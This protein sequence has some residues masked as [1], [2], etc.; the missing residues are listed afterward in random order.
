MSAES[1]STAPTEQGPAGEAEIVACVL[2]Y[3]EGW[4]EGDPA[5][6]R[7]ALHPGLAKRALL[8][9]EQSLDE[10][11]A[12]QMI[13]ATGRGGGT[14]RDP[15]RIE[16][17]VEDVYGSIAAATVRSAVYREY[18]QLARTQDGW[19]IVNALWAWT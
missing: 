1:P 9:D 5:R 4:F 15:G 3:F 13:E 17:E 14:A 18:V 2:D 6:M 19:K 8:A 11:T 7:R 10:T 12:Q 16:V